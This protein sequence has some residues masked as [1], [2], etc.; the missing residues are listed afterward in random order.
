[1]FEPVGMYTAQQS[2]VH[3][4]WLTYECY[5]L[6]GSGPGQVMFSQ[7][8]FI[9]HYTPDQFR[10]VN[11]IPENDDRAINSTSTISL[12]INTW[13]AGTSISNRNQ[14]VT[15]WVPYITKCNSSDVRDPNSPCHNLQGSGADSAFLWRI[16]VYQYNGDDVC[17]KD[18]GSY[19]YGS[20][21]VCR[22]DDHHCGTNVFVRKVPIVTGQGSDGNCGSS[23]AHRKFKVYGQVRKVSESDSDLGYH[24][25]FQSNT[26][27]YGGTAQ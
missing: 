18:V 6:S 16:A 7:A 20:P 23:S 14:L 1:M 25:A 22:D 12:A 9:Q 10:G 26:A 5:D 19:N 4:C 3:S 2:G 24:G 11:W 21:V 27:V 13:D 17:N 15:K 8:S